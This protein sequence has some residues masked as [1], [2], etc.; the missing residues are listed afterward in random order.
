[1]ELEGLSVFAGPAF[2]GFKPALTWRVQSRDAGIFYTGDTGF[3]DEVAESANGVDLLVAECSFPDDSPADGHLSPRSAGRLARRAQAGKLL[4]VHLYP[5]FE[6]DPSVPA[7]KE[8]GGD[9]SVA[10]DGMV[11]DVGKD[12]GRY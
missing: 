9:V 1:M 5:V 8:F 4:R 12:G 2:H 6:E 7:G 3:S 10:S 11:I